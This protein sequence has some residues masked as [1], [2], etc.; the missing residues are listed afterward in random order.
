VLRLKK[1]PGLKELLN[2]DRVNIRKSLHA[3]LVDVFHLSAFLTVVRPVGRGV[4]LVP[5]DFE[6]ACEEP[7]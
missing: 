3:V 4:T 5:A 1:T 2:H 6:G 7:V